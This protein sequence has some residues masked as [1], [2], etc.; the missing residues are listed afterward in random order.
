[1]SHGAPSP[2]T[3]P[4]SSRATPSTA[5]SS[6]APPTTSRS[7]VSSTRPRSTSRRVTGEERWIPMVPIS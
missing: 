5:S 3:A 6:C 2:G 7:L 4:A 1:W